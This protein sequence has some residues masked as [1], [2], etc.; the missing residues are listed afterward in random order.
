MSTYLV[1]FVIGELDYVEA[2]DAN[3]VL[4]RV[5]T[6]IGKAHRGNF[7]LDVCCRTLPFYANYFDIEYPLPKMDLV[8]IPD[9]SA[10][11]ME[12]WGLVTYREMRL[13]VDEK[14]TSKQCKE[15]V[16]LVVGHECAHMWFGNLVTMD[17][18]TD[19]WLNEGFATWIEYLCVDYCYPEFQIWVSFN[20]LVIKPFLLILLLMFPTMIPSPTLFLNS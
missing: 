4:V 13:L 12:N 11:A 3:G 18:W 1:A 17:W 16:A 5:Y 7:A 14:E 8:A 9:F 20:S 19:L 15:D 2:H 10:G 6:A